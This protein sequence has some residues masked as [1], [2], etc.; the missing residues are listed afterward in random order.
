MMFFFFSN[1]LFLCF[2]FHF[3]L[4]SMAVRCT[5][6]LPTLE[7]KCIYFF[8]NFLFKRREKNILL[9]NYLDFQSDEMIPFFIET[10][11]TACRFFQVFLNI[12]TSQQTNKRTDFDLSNFTWYTPPPFFI[13]FF[14]KYTYIHKHPF[15]ALLK[16]L[17]NI[18]ENAHIKSMC[19][20]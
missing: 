10:S 7:I 14:T 18:E 2:L 11:Q 16:K 19:Q 4:S 20:I 8:G 17:I 13:L 3:T 1:T 5:S 6:S 9:P 12:I 15:L